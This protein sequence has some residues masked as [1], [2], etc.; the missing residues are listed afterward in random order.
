MIKDINQQLSLSEKWGCQLCTST[1]VIQRQRYDAK[2]KKSKDFGVCICKCHFF[3]VSSA[4]P[5]P[6]G[7]FPPKLH[8]GDAG[9]KQVF[10]KKN[11]ATRLPF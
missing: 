6:S 9:H 2:I 11:D 5:F 7:G 8:Y 10:T 1:F 4:R 3:F